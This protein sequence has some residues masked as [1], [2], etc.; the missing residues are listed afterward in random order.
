MVNDDA[1]FGEVIRGMHNQLTQGNTESEPVRFH[2]DFSKWRWSKEDRAARDQVERMIHHVWVADASA[3]GALREKLDAKFSHDY[4]TGYFETTIWPSAKV[5]DGMIHFIDY[6]RFLAARIPTPSDDAV[7]HSGASENFLRGMPA[8]AG[9][10]S[11]RVVLVDE[12]TVSDIEFPQG[13]ILVCDNTDVRYLPLMRKA[14]AIVTNRG[15]ML[16]H[17]S[18]VA[19][20]LGVPCVVG[21]R[22]AT[23]VLK[24]GDSVE[25]DATTGIIRAV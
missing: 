17:A 6:N 22:E 10:A 7:E 5:P 15:G 12:S 16:S 4:L 23:R 21:T 25:V 1:I 8:H 18:I 9:R 3:Q 24:T 2:Y 20:E 11:G 14:A 19:R 13:S